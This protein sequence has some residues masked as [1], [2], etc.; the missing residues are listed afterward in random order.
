MEPGP[1]LAVEGLCV[2]FDSERGPLRAV[3]GVALE[4]RAGEC[5][6]VVG[7]SG[8]GKSQSFL[9]CLGLLASNGHA[10]GSARFEGREL[11]GASEAELQR[12]RGVRI[13]MVFQDPMN[14]LTPHL[15]IGRQLTE[16]V[17]DR[18]LMDPAQARARAVETLRAVG[19]TD[20]EARLGQY[21]HELS[22][23]QQQRVAIAMALMTDPVLLV[24]DEPTTALDVTVQSQVLAVLRGLRRRGLA[25][26]LVTHDLGVVAGIADRVIVMYAGRVVESA[27]V[28]DVFAAPAHPYTA[29]LLDSIPRIDGGTAKRLAGIPG[30]PPR[31]G[32]RGDG[33]A[34]AARCPQ[35][36]E[37]CHGEDPEARTRGLRTV[38]CH[39][40][41]PEGWGA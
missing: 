32:E 19:I 10:S 20:P 18:R 34:F 5:V 6:A 22:G 24:A 8:S 11:V 40:P 33:C 29:A 37:R 25:L 21:P 9:A 17:T 38:A 16:V 23:G 13:G 12:I 15:R 14:A 41:L 2:D 27:P 7:E 1:L 3:S 4:V 31:P 30:Q 36:R 28:G 39:A 35:V 26:V